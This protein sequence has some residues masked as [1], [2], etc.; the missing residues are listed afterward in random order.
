MIIM[1]GQ[2]C[3]GL[4]GQTIKSHTVRTTQHTDFLYI[5][6]CPR[7]Q[8]GCSCSKNLPAVITIKYAPVDI[9]VASVKNR[10]GLAR[11]GSWF[12]TEG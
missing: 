4:V 3:N 2:N 12:M 9:E 10:K 5:A 6:Q 1:G 7:S 8:E 11:A